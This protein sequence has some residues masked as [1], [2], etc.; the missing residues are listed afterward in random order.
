MKVYNGK[1]NNKA[2]RDYSRRRYRNP[3]FGAKSSSA[4]GRKKDFGQ[5]KRWLTVAALAGVV[6]F[7][8]WYL[9]WSSSFKITEIV[10]EGAS[11]D[12]S[13]IIRETLEKRL[14]QRR[15]LLFPQSAVFVYDTTTAAEDIRSQFYLDSLEI[16]RKLPHTVTVKIQEKNSVAVLLSAGEFMT[17]DNSGFVVRKLTKRE[18]IA[19]TD[20]P[21][22]M[23]AVETGELG[24]ESVVVADVTDESLTAVA[25]DAK[26]NSNPMPLILD[27]E[28]VT[29][30]LTPGSQ[31]IAPEILTLSLEA[32][33]GLPNVINSGIRW[34]ALE[35]ATDTVDV[36]LREGWH[37]YLTTMIPFSKQM[38][39][40]SLVM[41]ENIGERR[42]ELEYIDL[43]Y[44]ERIF[45]RFKN[46]PVP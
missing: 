24:A 44:D 18:R 1:S 4:R 2:I 36:V 35:S 33:A 46:E 3:F 42:A 32:Y 5:I 15:F 8:F 6:L 43:R 22:G 40:L 31:A 28:S 34:F 10:V 11:A 20:L 39:R 25:E 45:F 7:V 26:K 29:A 21:D 16:K 12:T 30:K 14:E 38:E 17:T 23:G 9:F 19:M 37:I 41:Q 27:R 13:P